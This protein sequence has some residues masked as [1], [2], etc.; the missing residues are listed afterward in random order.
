MFSRIFRN[1]KI[2]CTLHN[3]TEKLRNTEFLQLTALT[4]TLVNILFILY[5]LM[6]NILHNIQGYLD[7]A[8]VSV[9][10]YSK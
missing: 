6:L 9:P 2:L 1:N 3:K 8:S 5:K 4:I 7:F 10:R